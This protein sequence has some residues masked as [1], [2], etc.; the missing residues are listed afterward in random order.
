MADLAR[1]Q[2]SPIAFR[3]NLLVD[4][5]GEPKPLSSVIDEWQ[6]RDFIRTDQAWLRLCGNTR[7]MGPSRAY[8]ERCR[9]ASKTTDLAVQVLWVMFASRKKLTGIAAA[10]DQDQARLLRDAIDGL[11]RMNG[12]LRP[13]IKVDQLAV[14]NIKTGTKLTIL[15]SD[16]G[17]SYG[18][19]P[20]FLILDEV[21]HWPEKKGEELFT[22]LF[23]AAAKRQNCVVVIISNAGFGMGESWQWRVRESAR[24]DR[25]WYYHHLDQ[26]PSWISQELLD[27]QKRL[28]P[29]LS[30]RRLWLNEWT[31]GSG[32]A[33]DADD[34]DR[35]IT[36]KG[37]LS[38]PQ[39]GWVYY[40]G[41]DL[42]LSRDACAFCLVGRHIGYVRDEEVEAELTARQ[43]M[44]VELGI[45]DKP[46]S[47]F[48][49]FRQRPTGKL[50]LAEMIVWRPSGNRRVVLSAVEETIFDLA[51]EF[52]AWIGVDPW[53]AALLMERLSKRGVAVERVDFVP[54]NLKSMCSAV[55]ESFRE[56]Q[57][58]LYD[59]PR[60]ISDLR[61]LRVEE[62]GYGVRLV[63]PRGPQGHG[64]AATSLAI[65]LHMARSKDVF[66]HREVENIIAC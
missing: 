10:A 60:L 9:G 58:Q 17:S 53:Q 49:M 38:H 13:I 21:A 46:E 7:T 33:L 44:L 43:K 36:R 12:W 57:V 1:M 22:S 6:G 18:L 42:G 26:T 5:N 3:E 35:A 2:Q 20:D 55:L 62:K 25:S 4:C 23:S 34:I 41:V 47:K 61:Q 40:G 63:S 30:Y 52:N 24:V 32:D 48:K 28:L 14:T 31:S 39:D 45:I 15:A 54:G 29:R 50:R 66:T 65:A 56:R 11:V 59:H 64:D 27:E 37:P 19:T 16:V 51:R 8:L